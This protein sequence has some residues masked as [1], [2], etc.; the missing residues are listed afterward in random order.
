MTKLGA[1]LR[2]SIDKTITLLTNFMKFQEDVLSEEGVN[3]YQGIK[4]LNYDIN[5]K[6]IRNSFDIIKLLTD[7]NSK[8]FPNLQ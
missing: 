4:L 5:S 8:Q 7:N 6:S 3:K 1:S 2:E